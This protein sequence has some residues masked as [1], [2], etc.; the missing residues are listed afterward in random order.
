MM[1]EERFKELCV[2]KVFAYIF[3]SLGALVLLS[4]YMLW[5]I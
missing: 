1:A 4:L 2:N 3:I 5:T